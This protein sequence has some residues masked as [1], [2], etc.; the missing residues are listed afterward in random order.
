ML[1]NP[2]KPKLNFHNSCTVV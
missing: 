2:L 1:F